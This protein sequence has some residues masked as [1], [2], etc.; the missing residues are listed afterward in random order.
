MDWKVTWLLKEVEGFEGY[1]EFAS[2]ERAR[3]W[4]TKLRRGGGAYMIVL[5]YTGGPKAE[6]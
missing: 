6:E 4:I 5:T 3:G 1:E 2:E